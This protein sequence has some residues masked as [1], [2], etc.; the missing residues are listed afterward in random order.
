MNA[1]DI[2]D[3]SCKDPIY[4]EIRDDCDEEVLLLSIGG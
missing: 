2:M 4:I 3:L 1:M